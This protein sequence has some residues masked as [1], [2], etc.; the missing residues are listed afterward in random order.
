MKKLLLTIFLGLGVLLSLNG[1]AMPAEKPLRIA[2]SNYPLVYFAERIGG[3]A[4]ETLFQVPKD[5]DPAFWKPNASAIG[6]MQKADLIAL[7]GADY[8]K[9]L[10][11]VSLPKAKRVDTSEAFRSQFIKI[12]KAVTHSHGPGGTHSHA[13]TAFTTWLDFDQAA[14]Q[15]DALAVAMIRQRP[16]QAEKFRQGLSSLKKDL[17]TLDE[18]MRKTGLAHAGKPLMGSH[19]VYQYL[20]RRYGIRLENVHW[21][22]NVMP[23]V[24]EWQVLA[25]LRAKHPASL[26]IWEGQPSPEISAR[27]N[28]SGLE[29]VV[30]DPCA[31]RPDSGDFLSVMR[32]NITLLGKAWH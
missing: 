1:K 5:E 22:P 15:A 19:P 21:E 23:D 2:A 29:S 18:D 20:A 30:F 12:E 8:E 14:R 27:L 13:G 7:N 25:A 32:R 3:D 10:A 11:R 9:W 4:I 16:G 17:A 24:A 31:N 26:M 28:A 6:A